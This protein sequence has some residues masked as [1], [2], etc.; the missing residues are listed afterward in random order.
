M[1]SEKWAKVVQ[2][3]GEKPMS[4][5]EEAAR[6]ELTALWS[7]LDEAMAFAID[8]EWSMRC[9]WLTGRIVTLSR[10]VGVTPWLDIP[11]TVLLNG[12]YQGIMAA[13]GLAFEAPGEDD[14]RRM[15]AWRRG[16]GFA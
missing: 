4:G 15:Q 9:D 5:L 16:D 6:D 11:Y 13:A 1:G 8:G 3:A 2:R 10:L 7:D 12:A 14:L